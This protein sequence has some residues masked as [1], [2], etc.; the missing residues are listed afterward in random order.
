M[1]ANRWWV[2]LLCGAA[3]AWPAAAQD[4]PAPNS[5]AG[6]ETPK[7]EA[8]KEPPAK[9]A[10][11]EPP[12]KRWGGMEIRVGAFDP[13][14][15]GA[16]YRAAAV[17]QT[18]RQGIV[19][20]ILELPADPVVRTAVQARWLLPRDRGSIE[21]AYDSI[22]NSAFLQKLTPG[23]FQYGE[24]TV[25][26]KYA[27]VAD[28]SLADGF[29]SKSLTKAR[30]FRLEYA[31]PAFKTARSRGRWHAGLHSVDF[32]RHFESRYY[33]LAPDLPPT[34]PPIL[35]SSSGVS[36]LS[37][38]PD[39]AI[40]DSKFSGLGPSAGFDVSFD[41]VPRVSVIGGIALGLVAGR[42][43][44]KYAS[45]THTYY[46]QPGQDTPAG[47]LS[48]SDLSAALDDP[49]LASLVVQLD[50]P[51]N[52]TDANAGHVAE[53]FEAYVGVEGRIWHELRAYARLRGLVL[54]NAA[55]D[56]TPSA[57]DY[58]FDVANVALAPRA[59]GVSQETRSVGYVGFEAGVSFRY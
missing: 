15:Y 46:L 4:E 35:P 24:L 29:R 41:I 57:V 47:F 28:N 17:Y 50:A 27:G 13:D 8:P 43:D 21:I 38:R 23:V 40:V 16:D 36:A 56:A 30:R 33:A 31:F 39:S 53:D 7:A 26:S 19:S 49:D 48:F 5:A 3:L 11:Q 52:V 54:A 44:T 18:G 22:H 55:A 20:Q 32:S 37:P 59:S 42:L 51:V 12:L 45:I 58:A 9:K 2:V 34:I 25:P 10:Y 14:F 1:K 6:T